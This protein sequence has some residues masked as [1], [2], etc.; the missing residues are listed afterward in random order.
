MRIIIVSG[1]FYPAITPRSFR[2]TELVK[3]LSRRGAEVTLYIPNDGIDRS[4]FS[5]DYHV[6]IHYYHRP[7]DKL[8]KSN[9]K[10]IYVLGRFLVYYAQYPEIYLL[11]TLRKALEQEKDQYDLLISIAAPHPIHW[12]IGRIYKSG[13]RI[14]KKWVADCG[15]PFM[16]AGTL[17]RKHPFYL[18]PFEKL[19]C[20]LC[21]YITVPTVGAING[22]YPEFRNKIK[23]IPQAFDFNEI[24]RVH[25]EKKPIPSFIYSGSIWKGSKDPRPFLDYLCGLSLDFRFYVYTNDGQALDSY[26]EKLKEKLVISPFIPRL[27]LI[28]IMSGMDFLVH[29]EFGTSKQ[30]P[31]KLIDYTLSGRPI[32]ALNINNL[33]ESLINH[34]LNG[35]YSKQFL[36][37]NIEQYNIINVAQQ[38]LDLCK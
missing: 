16:L 26:K 34:F 23:V 8:S 25:Y 6:D 37:D 1:Y 28:K 27:D 22:Y 20:R 36:V 17:N 38:F 32:L 5:N 24:E 18:K 4:K 15:D 3:E 29:F 9:N 21:D 12:T 19:W 7:E 35:D 31:S 2:T 33:D 13:N 14:A 30:T 10:L 11:K